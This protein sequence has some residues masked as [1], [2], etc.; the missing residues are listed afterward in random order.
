MHAGVCAASS[1]VVRLR[2]AWTQMFC[3]CVLDVFCACVYVR[4]V[5]SLLVEA[6]IT[7]I[8]RR[9][10]KYEPVAIIIDCIVVKIDFAI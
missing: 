5:L 2:V 4:D 9:L 7:I 3:F 10:V 1:M 6:S 8:K